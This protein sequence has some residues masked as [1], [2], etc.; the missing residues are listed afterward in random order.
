MWYLKNER[1]I[2][3]K[4]NGKM[5]R[6]QQY[7]TITS[8]KRSMQPC[9]IIKCSY[10][11]KVIE[12][13]KYGVMAELRIVPSILICCISTKTPYMIKQFSSSETKPLIIHLIT[14]FTWSGKNTAITVV[15]ATRVF[16]SCHKFQ[17]M[18]VVEQIHQLV[19]LVC[20]RRDYEICTNNVQQPNDF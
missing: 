4:Y 5:E 6:V 20:I 1:K 12:Q 11:L 3:K 14:Q 17:Y 15:A 9:T 2:I 19:Y 7:A 16:L 13:T 18:W 10:S 8:I